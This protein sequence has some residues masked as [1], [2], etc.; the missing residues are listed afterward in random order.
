MAGGTI[1]RPRRHASCPA[2]RASGFAAAALEESSKSDRLPVSVERKLGSDKWREHVF[3]TPPIPPKNLA[4]RPAV[5]N[6]PKFNG[7]TVLLEGVNQYSAASLLDYCK[8]AGSVI[9]WKSRAFEWVVPPSHAPAVAQF[10]V[11]LAGDRKLLVVQTKGEKYLNSDALK[12]FKDERVYAE[13]LGLTHL[14]WTDKKPLTGKLRTV[15]GRIRG[16]RNTL[17]EA[18]DLDRLVEFVEREGRPT[19][20]D[21]VAADLDPSQIARAV[22]EKRLFVPLE[23][24]YDGNMVV[25]AQPQT[26]L[27]SF[28]LMQS[29]DPQ[30][31]WKSLRAV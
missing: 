12:R 25:T 9:R 18:G 4:S 22:W 23:S 1:R 17:V 20:R 7:V 31:W 11:E 30:R 3:S 27:R 13:P 16:A 29:F 6:I 26:D 21:I 24:A 8:S 5:R 14:V 19:V 10:L 15:L 2:V 28:L